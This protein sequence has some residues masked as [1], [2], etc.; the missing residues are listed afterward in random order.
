MRA[1]ALGSRHSRRRKYR[2]YNGITLLLHFVL[3]LLLTAS[4]YPAAAET[5]QLERRGGGYIIPVQINKAII[6]PFV[7]DTGSA[8]V[9]IPSDV[10]LTLLRTGTVNEGDL[11]RTGTYVLADGSEQSSDRFI[12]HELRVGD[13]IIR[14]VIANVAPV[15]G[16]PLLGQSFLAKLPAWTIDNTRHALVLNDQPGSDSGLSARELFGRGSTAA[17]H[18][19]YTEAMRWY[20]MVADQGYAAA[21]FNVGM[22]YFNGWGVPQ[23]YAEAMRWFRMAADQGYALAQSSIG[24]LYLNGRGVPLDYTEAMRWC[25]MAA[26]QGDSNAK[27][28]IG[29]MAA[30]GDGVSKDCVVAGQWLE[31]AAAAGN[32][33]ARLDLS[34][35]VNGACQW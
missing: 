18:K 29:I 32:E 7:L 4:L 11:I 27:D 14:N 1:L 5:I 25:Q 6:L 15:K 23:D 10:F 22:L 13:H 34:S 26:A 2:P 9:S 3:V 28:D 24:W 35:G 8:E 30:L 31:Q 12:L 21:Q 33:K 19:N 17:F 16:D 20:R